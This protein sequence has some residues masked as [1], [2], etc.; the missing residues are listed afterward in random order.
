MWDA[1]ANKR[2]V[3]LEGHTAR[4]GALAW[5]GDQLSSGSRDRMILQRDIRSRSAVASGNSDRKLAGHR[6]EVRY[7]CLFFG[8]GAMAAPYAIRSCKELL[9][10][11]T[12][13]F[14]LTHFYPCVIFVVCLFV[15]RIFILLSREKA[16]WSYLLLT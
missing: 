11:R 10:A 6:Q 13:S 1:S 15:S 4:V 14:A 8:K 16:P 3:Q 12:L 7:L 2:I 9:K 5:N